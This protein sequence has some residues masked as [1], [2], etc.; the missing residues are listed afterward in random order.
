MKDNRSD[1]IPVPYF[2]LNVQGEIL[3]CSKV[4]NTLFQ[5]AE[6]FLDLVHIDDRFKA[7][8]SLLQPLSN[9]EIKV[10][11][12]LKV[13]HVFF[14]LFTCTINWKDNVG[15]LVCMETDSQVIQLESQLE[16][17]K[18]LLQ[19][20]QAL[21]ESNRLILTFTNKLVQRLESELNYNK[22]RFH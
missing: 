11:L 3:H 20:K 8:E 17:Q 6:H 1:L 16:D 21:I 7:Q 14:G 5:P 2:M 9:E 12:I 4:V 13:H 18:Q 19:T 15:Y 22:T 10:N